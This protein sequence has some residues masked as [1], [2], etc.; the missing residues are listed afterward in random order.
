MKKLFALIL[1]VILILLSAGCTQSEQINLGDFIERFNTKSSLDEIGFVDFYV[2]SQNSTEQIYNCA[3]QSEANEI[4]LRLF[5]N[6]NGKIKKCS[7]IFPKSDENGNSITI[8]SSENELF[9]TVCTQT[10][11]AFSNSSKEEA[12]QIITELLKNDGKTEVVKDSGSFHYVLLEDTLCKRLMIQ[13]KWLCE[14]ETT[15]KPESKSAFWQET[16]VRTET[17]PHR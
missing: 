7:V 15:L 13:N 14:I 8:S 16:S 17:V 9:K 12:Q 1:S 2:L 10:A 5:E 6:S 3:F 11:S 4:L